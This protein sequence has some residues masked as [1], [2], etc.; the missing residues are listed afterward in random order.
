M[1]ETQAQPPVHVSVPLAL[2]G[3]TLGQLLAQACREAKSKQSLI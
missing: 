3:E 2:L 1:T